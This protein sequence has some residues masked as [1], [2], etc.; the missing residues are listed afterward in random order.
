MVHERPHFTT[1]GLMSEKTFVS[2]I[3]IN[4]FSTGDSRAFVVS[5][6][7]SQEN[8]SKTGG[9]PLNPWF[10]QSFLDQ[11]NEYQF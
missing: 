5:M 6:I 10:Q 7:D 4:W 2:F 9:K 3:A 1:L 8:I 11:S